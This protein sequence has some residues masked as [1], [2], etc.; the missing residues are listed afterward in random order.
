MYDIL[1]MLLPAA[2]SIGDV[3]TVHQD[4][5]NSKRYTSD[6]IRI[7]GVTP[8]GHKFTLRLELEDKKDDT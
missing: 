7:E 2:E 1:K 4:I 5:L 8:D 3:T 6:E